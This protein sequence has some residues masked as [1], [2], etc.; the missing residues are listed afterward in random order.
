MHGLSFL[1]NNETMGA[2]DSSNH[3]AICIAEICFLKVMCI[4]VVN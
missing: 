1:S 4:F 2:I 3:S